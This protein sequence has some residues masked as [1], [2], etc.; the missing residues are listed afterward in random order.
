MVRTTD[1]I[2][3]SWPGDTT[4]NYVETKTYT[5]VKSSVNLNTNGFA[6]G[7]V[8]VANLVLRQTRDDPITYDSAETTH[9]TILGWMNN[10]YIM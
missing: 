10:D 4:F 3:Y 7:T 5:F 6:V 8:D 1:G 9:P 2:L